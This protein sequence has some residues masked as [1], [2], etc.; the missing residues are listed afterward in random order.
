VLAVGSL[1]GSRMADELADSRPK[2]RRILAFQ[3]LLRQ[4][5]R[6]ELICQQNTFTGRLTEEMLDAVFQRA[7]ELGAGRHR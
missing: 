5:L 7:G 6:P 3:G 1:E 4:T 2:N